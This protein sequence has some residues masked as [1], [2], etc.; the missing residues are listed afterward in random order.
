[1][2]S[3]PQALLVIALLAGPTI[4]WLLYR[5]L[6]LRM[7]SRWLA[8]YE[9]EREVGRGTSIDELL[10]SDFVWT[11]PACI[12]LNRATF[13]ECYRCHA[14]KPRPDDRYENPIDPAPVP[15]MA[16]GPRIPSM[17]GAVAIPDRPSA[18]VE[19]VAVKEVTT[20]GSP[21]H[22]RRA[23][24]A[25][26]PDVAAA[27]RPPLVAVP[28]PGAPAA[29]KVAV[30]RASAS[31]SQTKDGSLR[32]PPRSGAPASA[33]VEARCPLLG[34]RS[35]RSTYFLMAHPEH[36]CHAEEHPTVIDRGHQEA[37][38]LTPE[39]TSC[40]I[41]RARPAAADRPPHDSVRPADSP[42]PRSGLGDG[43]ILGRL[44]R[45]S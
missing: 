24:M 35:D 41:Y 2:E 10:G 5:R 29:A 15:V 19:R 11:C 8:D 16:I 28:G 7:P 43:A 33:D 38:C 32:L 12:F 17:V 26:V 1:V 30:R 37:F 9:P 13:D 18:A 31:G 22:A 6:R 21:R 42:D 27:G 3:F 23:A 34:L 45:R 40:V 44:L 25:P 14:P 39:F 4:G 36:R 20:G